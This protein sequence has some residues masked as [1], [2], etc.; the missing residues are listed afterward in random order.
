M[1]LYR[2]HR[3]ATLDALVGNDA[4][5]EA[6]DGIFNGPMEDWPRSFM[7]AGPSGCGKTTIARI[8]ARQHIKA[9]EMNIR[10][11]NTADNR[12]ID[13]AREIIDTLRYVPPGGG[14]LVYIIDECH[15][16][17]KEWQNAMLK[18]LEDGPRW[19][20]F[21]LCTTIP[22]KLD[23][24][25]HT[26]CTQITVQPQDEK[27]LFRLVRRVAKAEK[28]EIAD[29]VLEALATAAGG[30]PR[31]ALVALEKVATMRTEDAQMQ[32]VEGSVE[33]ETETRELCQALLG[34]DWK[35]VAV[36]LQGLRQQDAEKTRRAVLGY[37]T[38]VV[39]SSGKHKAALVLQAFQEHT[40]DVGFPGV[41]CMAYAAMH[42]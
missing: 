32:A 35:P 42:Q 38:S 3:P 12:G 18:P 21:F 22:A 15:M 16:T 31:A 34:S 8:I 1:S 7:V 10:E 30:S 9:S 4:Q 29:R 2:K 24:A 39:L 19:V 25:I 23:K 41:V 40:Y 28:F 14:P 26:R 6:L 36:A 13:T 33:E 17:T 37:M 20:F 5:I 27:S 11:V